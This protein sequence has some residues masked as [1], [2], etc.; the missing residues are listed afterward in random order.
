M[1]IK[2]TNLM[3][4]FNSIKEIG[5]KLYQHADLKSFRRSHV[6]D[7]KNLDL[8]IQQY[9]KTLVLPKKVLKEITLFVSFI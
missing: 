3:N 2:K 8:N 4:L 6:F 7:C 9:I 1:K 5:L